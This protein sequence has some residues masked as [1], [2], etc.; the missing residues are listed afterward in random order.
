MLGLEG[1]GAWQGETVGLRG[2]ECGQ[3]DAELVE[4]QRGD[5]FVEVL[6]QYID[7][8]LVFAV[9]DPQFDLAS[10]WLVNHALITK[11]G[12]PVAQ[13]RLT[14]RPLASTISR[15]PSGKTTSSTCGLTS[16]QVQLRMPRSEVRRD[17]WL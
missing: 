4:V 11:L 17:L 16:S 12:R 8:V 14:S 7:F 13:P 10:T 9:I 1:P 2:A 3:L 15:L 6:G 5:S